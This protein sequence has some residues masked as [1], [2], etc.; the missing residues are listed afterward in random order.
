MRQGQTGPPSPGDGDTGIDGLTGGGSGVDGAGLDGVRDG[1]GTAGV[2]SGGGGGGSFTRGW[3]AN[4]IPISSARTS[5]AAASVIT[6]AT[7]LRSGA[8]ST[9][10]GAPGAGAGIGRSNAGSP[11]PSQY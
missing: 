11:D 6:A 7:M 2:G 3:H 4:S 1:D 9:T 10:K 8:R 5:S